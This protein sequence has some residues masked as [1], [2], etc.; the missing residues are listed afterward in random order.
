MKEGVKSEIVQRREERK[1]KQCN[2]ERG[3]NVKQSNDGWSEQVE[4]SPTKE[5]TIKRKT[6][7]ND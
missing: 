3:E 5:R 1:V 7:S 2:E 6:L 4:R